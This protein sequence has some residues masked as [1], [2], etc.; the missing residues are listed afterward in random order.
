MKV[1]M[2]MRVLVLAGVGLASTLAWP[3]AAQQ[4]SDPF[5]SI[6]FREIGP[7]RQ[8]GRFVE[9]AVV[10]A[11]PRI[12]YAASATGGVFKTENAGL[13]F[14]QVFDSFGAASIGA[15]AVSQSNPDVLYLGSGE[16]NTSRTTYSGD[17]VY[18]SGDAGKTWTNVGLR[19]SHHI[20]R[21]VIHPTDPNTAYVAALGHLYSTNDERGL[22]KT[23]DGGKTWTKSLDIKSSG[24]SIGVV[25]VAMDPKNPLVLYAST[26]EK[27]RKP[28]SFGP[29]GLGSG[30]HKSIDG[31]KT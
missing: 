16:G 11:T 7:T 22:Y 3:V 14:A 28:F 2:S 20:G 23:I 13:F 27:M 17:G 25:D 19:D 26:Y 30:L 31:G 15:I 10:E 8:G 12:F 21:I 4:P 1:P 5:K 18:K 24:Q 29:G 9:F 6:S